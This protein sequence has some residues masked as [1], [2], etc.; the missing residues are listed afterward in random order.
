VIDLPQLLEGL[1]GT[2]TEAVLGMARLADRDLA[3]Y[4]RKRLSAGPGSPDAFLA[5]PQIEGAF[6]WMPFAGGWDGLPADLLHPK[7]VETLR[8][9][10]F[11]P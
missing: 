2:S 7:T 6:P 8:R 9:V 4:L 10:A 11:P 3:A 1:P 5:E